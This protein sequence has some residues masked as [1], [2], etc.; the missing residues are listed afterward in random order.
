MDETQAHPKTRN[1]GA[2]KICG[3]SFSYMYLNKPLCW[4]QGDLLHQQEIR[5]RL[6]QETTFEIV[7]QKIEEDTNRLTHRAIQTA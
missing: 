1:E 6:I 5:Y 4:D 2:I 7:R 3:I